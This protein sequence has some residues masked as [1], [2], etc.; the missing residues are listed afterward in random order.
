[1][2]MQRG[3]VGDRSSIQ[4]L[5]EAIQ[6]RQV[7]LSL[8]R[9]MNAARLAGAT[10]VHCNAEFRSDLK[11]S[12]RNSPMLR[13][14][15]K[16]PSHILSGSEGAEVVQELAPRPEDLVFRRFHGL[17]PFSGTSL[18]ITL[19]NLGVDTVVAAGVSVNMGVFGMCLEAVNLG[20]RVILARDCVGGFP[21][22]Y[23][24]A[25]IDK[26]LSLLATISTA[27]ELAAAWEAGS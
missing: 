23:V 3:V 16:D 15:T 11:G 22:D 12:G 7:I 9:L 18:D 5:V 17:S 4:P 25:V 13:Y 19:R 8:A 14:V 27:D 21:D 26:S 10:V 20:Y 24:D 1:M 6:R 2:E